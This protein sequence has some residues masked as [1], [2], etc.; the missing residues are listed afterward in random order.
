MAIALLVP[1]VLIDPRIPTSNGREISVG[2]L[3]DNMVSLV[4]ESDAVA[5]SLENPEICEACQ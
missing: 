4:G 1:V 3:V 2:Q 5:C